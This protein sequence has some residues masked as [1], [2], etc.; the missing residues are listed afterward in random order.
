MRGIGPGR[1]SATILRR[2]TPV[3]TKNRPF[4]GLFHLWD[5]KM[6]IKKARDTGLSF[7]TDRR[8]REQKEKE[9][10][11]DGRGH[12]F[13]RLNTRVNVSH[14]TRTSGFSP[15]PRFCRVSSIASC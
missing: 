9:F 10:A 14:Q 13:H 8:F 3:S 5:V 15:N 11:K 1:W 12:P 7:I 6:R 4:S 2:Q